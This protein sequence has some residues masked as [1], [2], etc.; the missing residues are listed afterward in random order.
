MK[1]TSLIVVAAAILL[2]CGAGR[3]N[4]DGITYTESATAT[5]SIGATNF[6]G[7]LVTITFAEIRLTSEEHWAFSRTLRGGSEPLRL[8]TT[9]GS[10][11]FKHLRSDDCHWGPSP[12]SRGSIRARPMGTSAGLLAFNGHVP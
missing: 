11:A 12:A 3:A 1:R 2:F 4:A 7:A 8:P 9:I 5:G 10:S 6:T